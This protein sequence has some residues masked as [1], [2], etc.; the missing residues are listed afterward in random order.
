MKVIEFVQSTFNNRE[1]SLAFWFIVFLVWALSQKKIKGSI[2][3]LIKIIFSK[4]LLRINLLMIVY[5][6]FILFLLFRINFW[7]ISLL[8]DTIYWTFGVAFIM[9][10]NASKA[11]TEPYFFKKTLLDNLKFTLILEFVVNFYSLNLIWELILLPI[12]VLLAGMNAVSEL[13]KEHLIVKNITTTILSI[14]GV[15]Y[16]VVGL[17]KVFSNFT[18]FILYDNLRAFMFP[19]IMVCFYLP[20][21]YLIALYMQYETLFNRISVRISE[22]KKLFR[23]VKYQIFRCSHFNLKKITR[24][25]ESVPVYNFYSRE[26]ILDYIKKFNNGLDEI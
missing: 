6:S 13:E 21:I 23:F 3:S 8:K 1:I 24:F 19:V 9:L 15:I 5:L 7:K 25:A 12:V 17:Y 22:N 20:F 4:A 14:I 10:M 11:Y 16:A 2:F 26:D 18:D